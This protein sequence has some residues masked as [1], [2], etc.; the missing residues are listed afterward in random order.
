MDLL[1]AEPELVATRPGQT[2]TGDKNYF[3]RDFEHQPAGHGIRLPRPIRT[4]EPEQPG[5]ELFTPPRQVAESVNET[6]KGR[7]D[8]ERH[9]G[10][11]PADVVARVLRRI[12]RRPPASGAT[13]GADNPFMRLLGS[14]T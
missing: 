14:I 11:T 10:R 4:G 13:A 2:L 12:S 5:A 8:L 6:F 7:L 1:D 9:H 3:G